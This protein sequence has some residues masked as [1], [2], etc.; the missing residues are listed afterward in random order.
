MTLGDTIKAKRA[1]YRPRVYAGPG[2]NFGTD[3][4]LQNRANSVKTVLF[5]RVR[6]SFAGV[7][8][9]MAFLTKGRNLHN[10]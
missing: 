4:F 9:G 8:F 6:K 7:S 3:D 10:V 5:T 2:T 1:N